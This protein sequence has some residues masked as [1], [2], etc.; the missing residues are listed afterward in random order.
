[1]AQD[2]IEIRQSGGVL[3]VTMDDTPTRNAIGVEMARAIEAQLGRLDS[4]PALRVLVLT[5]RDPSFCSGAN[6]RR[7]DDANRARQPSEA[8]SLPQ[9]PW[10]ALER[11]WA[12]GAPGGSEEMDVVRMLPVRLHKLQKPSIAAVNGHAVGLGMGLALSCDIRIASERAQFSE[13]FVKN[14]L[15]PA[16]GSCWQLP[17]IIGLGNT[18]LLQ[19]TG[20]LIAAE[21]AYRM[22][23]VAKVVPHDDLTGAAMELA[24]RLAQG[25]TYSMGLI[26]RLVQAS[27]DVGFEE[28][29]RLAG[30]AQEL[31]RQTEDHR[32]G[33]RAFVEKRRPSFKGR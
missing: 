6:V 28:S 17:R 31:A 8:A 25:P 3:M 15:I 11:E 16:D 33:V 26:K 2:Y 24:Q 32:E 12:K 5:G 1:M 7:M 10:A 4:D 27:L 29:M 13:A 20:D 22:G 23:L 9:S 19:Y 18:F 14:G 21:E 30:P